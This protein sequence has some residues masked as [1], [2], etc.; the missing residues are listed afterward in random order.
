MKSP[1]SAAAGLLHARSSATVWILGTLLLQVFTVN[2]QA[3]AFE[4]L[5]STIEGVRAALL[6]NSTTCHSVVSSFISRIEEFNPTVNALVSLNPNALTAANDLDKRLAAGDS[7]GKL[8]CVPVL[9]KDN[10]DAVGTNT[11]GANAALAGNSPSVDTPS[12]KAMK[13]E[14]AIILGKTNLHE[15]MY[16]LFPEYLPITR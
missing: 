4:P 13:D 2:A 11:T 12:V 10:Y 14:G 1:V 15:S 7:A 3:N 6:A 16:L 8:F 5:E 9:L